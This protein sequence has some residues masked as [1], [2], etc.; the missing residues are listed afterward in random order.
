MSTILEILKYIL[1]SLVVFAT[2][3]FLIQLILNRDLDLRAKEATL[4][5]KSLITPIRLQAFERIVLFLERISP[6]NLILRVNEA[7]MS[8]R[9]LQVSLIR[10]I[11]DEYEHNLSQQVYLSNKSWELVKT[12]KEDLIKIINSAA[13]ELGE[14]ASSTDLARKIFEAYL[15]TEKASVSSALDFVKKEIFQLF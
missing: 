3:Y 12:A 15:S 7:G 14:D 4:Q 2:A 8:S 6:Q 1:P 10:N 5:N 11:R 13:A 9:D